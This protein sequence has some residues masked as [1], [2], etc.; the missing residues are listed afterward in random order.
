M[1]PNLCQPNKILKKN[2][3]SKSQV[4]FK[5][6]QTKTIAMNFRKNEDFVYMIYMFSMKSF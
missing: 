3:R 2:Y 5:I 4:Q 1:Y 6:Q